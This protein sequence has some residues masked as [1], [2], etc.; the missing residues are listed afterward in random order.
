[1]HHRARI[2]YPVTR[3]LAEA[4]ERRV[5]A[6]GRGDEPPLNV[7]EQCPSNDVNRTPMLIPDTANAALTKE[8]LHAQ[9]FIDD[10]GHHGHRGNVDRR[11][12]ADASGDTA[13]SSARSPT[14]SKS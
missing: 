3:N 5:L 7:C 6:P 13:S 2:V 11:G 14:A 1:M 9:A 10:A 12:S 8:E 4:L